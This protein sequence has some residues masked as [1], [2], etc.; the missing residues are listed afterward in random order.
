[1]VKENIR[2]VGGVKGTIWASAGYDGRLT[3]EVV[4]F[5][6]KIEDAHWIWRTCGGIER[7]PTKAFKLENSINQQMDSFFHD[8]IPKFLEGLPIGDETGLR[9][10]YEGHSQVSTYC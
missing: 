2:K 8:S 6:P 3:L 4:E 9:T 10:A 1:V 7:I 5:E